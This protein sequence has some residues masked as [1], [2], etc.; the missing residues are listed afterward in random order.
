MMSTFWNTFYL[1]ETELQQLRKEIDALRRQQRQRSDRKRQ[2]SNRTTVAATENRRWRFANR[3]RAAENALT[4]LVRYL[5]PQ[6]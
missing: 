1:M 2:K 4:S 5:R 6:N 3:L